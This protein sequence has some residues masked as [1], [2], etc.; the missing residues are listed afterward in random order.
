MPKRNEKTRRYNKGHGALIIAPK[1]PKAIVMVG[2]SMLKI[3]WRGIARIVVHDDRNRGSIPADADMLLTLGI[4]VV[5][6]TVA[7]G[8]AAGILCAVFGFPLTE[9]PAPH[10]P[11]HPAVPMTDEAVEVAEGLNL[12]GFPDDEYFFPKLVDV[13]RR[14]FDRNPEFHRFCIE[15][16]SA[17]VHHRSNTKRLPRWP[18]SRARHWDGRRGQYDPFRFSSNG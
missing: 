10:G 9:Y 18:L 13:R 6:G 2:W 3:S 15:A 12:H 5:V 4:G 1:L 16:K 14:P 8:L 17:Q 7:I 11:G